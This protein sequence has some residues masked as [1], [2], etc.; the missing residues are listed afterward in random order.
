[1][2][3]ITAP[4]RELARQIFD[5][6]KKIINYADKEDEWRAQLLIGGTDKQRA[7][8][9]LNQPPQVIVGTPGRILDLVD[10]HAISIYNAKSFVIDEAD[11]MLDMGFIEDVD[12]L[13]VR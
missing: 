4:T 7:I 2:V 12:K 1:K 11:L 8:E 3:V 9:K 6:V 5:E 13:L 10:E